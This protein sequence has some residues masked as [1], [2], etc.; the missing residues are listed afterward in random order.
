M[1]KQITIYSIATQIW[2]VMDMLTDNAYLAPKICCDIPLADK[3]TLTFKQQFIFEN[4][5]LK[6]DHLPF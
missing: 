1:L 4:K 3:D 2:P 6:I 5:Q